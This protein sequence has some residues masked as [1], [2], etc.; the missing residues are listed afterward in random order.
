MQLTP[1]PAQRHPPGAALLAR[2]AAGDDKSEFWP[3]GDVSLCPCA[4][5]GVQALPKFSIFAP[6]G[7]WARSARTPR[8]SRRCRWG[9]RSTRTCPAPVTGSLIPA[10]TRTVSSSTRPCFGF[11]PAS[12]AAEAPGLRATGLGSG[13]ISGVWDSEAPVHAAELC[14]GSGKLPCTPTCRGGI[15]AAL[16]PLTQPPVCRSSSRPRKPQAKSPHP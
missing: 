8:S 3:K 4:G 13:S 12:G 15:A 5:V 10:G 6:L 2:R 1:K 9:L 16:R 11:A 7:C 14:Q